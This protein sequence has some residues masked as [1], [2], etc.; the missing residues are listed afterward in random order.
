[1]K[2]TFKVKYITY[3]KNVNITQHT[4]FCRIGT[5][6]QVTIVLLIK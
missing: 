1:M 5:Y 3:L 6:L 2:G 4:M